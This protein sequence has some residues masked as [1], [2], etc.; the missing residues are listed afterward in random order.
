MQPHGQDGGRDGVT[1]T[2]NMTGLEAIV[3]VDA[4]AGGW[5]RRL[6]TPGIVDS[7]RNFSPMYPRD[8]R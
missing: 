3:V 2:L 7:H 8:Q 6:M 4:G 5:N 1:S